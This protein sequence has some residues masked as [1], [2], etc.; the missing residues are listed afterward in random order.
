MRSLSAGLLMF[1]LAFAQPSAE[2]GRDALQEAYRNWRQADPALERDATSAGA[3]LGARADKAAA[4]GARYFAVRKAYLDKLARDAGRKASAVEALNIA[5]DSASNLE[6]YVSAQSTILESGARTISRDSDRGFQRLLQAF[7]QERAALAAISTAIK[8]MR[9]TEEV[10]VAATTTA[11]PK[12]SQAS[13]RYQKLAASFQQ[14]AQLAEESGAAWANYYRSLS[15]AARSEPAP[16][17]SAAPVRAPNAPEPAAAAVSNPAPAARNVA[18]IPLSRYL[19]SWM[20]G[21]GGAH[22]HGV[23]PLSV[24]MELRAE[25]GRVRGTLF[26]RFRLLPGGPT[27]PLVRFSFEGPFEDSRTQ[28]FTI[29]TSNGAPGIIE[30]LPG[31]AFNLLEVNFSTYDRPGMVRQGNFLLVKK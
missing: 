30:L 9:K 17:T 6:A 20:Y 31:P 18:P 5:P 12:R 29:I 22:Y 11:E 2:P 13:D 8:D 1:G 16:V 25:N 21:T 14:S 10:L 7:D 3:T 19:G 28:K 23:E 24:Q 4:E 26:A 27:D 15:S